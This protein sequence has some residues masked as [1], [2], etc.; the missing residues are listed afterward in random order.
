MVRGF[1]P[2]GTQ[3]VS[4]A[5]REIVEENGIAVV[6]C[7]WIHLEEIPWGRIKSPHERVRECGDLS[8]YAPNGI[9]IL[10]YAVPYLIAGNPVNHG[11]PWRLN[12]AE[13]LAAAFDIIGFPRLT[14]TVPEVQVSAISQTSSG[15][16]TRGA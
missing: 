9:P 12:C 14:R 16:D 11:K 5:D 13:A 8:F 7:S 2:Q 4:P 6:E 10:L 15:Y 1:R 3:V